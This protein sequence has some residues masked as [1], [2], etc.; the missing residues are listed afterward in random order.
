MSD[1]SE[2]YF[3][4]QKIVKMDVYVPEFSRSLATLE[5]FAQ[6][7][8]DYATSRM[9]AISQSMIIDPGRWEINRDLISMLDIETVCAQNI[10]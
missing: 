1:Y 3:T 9:R 7:R 8:L 5:A 4:A 2:V 10:D 6:P